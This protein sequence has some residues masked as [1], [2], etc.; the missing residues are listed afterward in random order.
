M[1]GLTRPALYWRTVHTPRKAQTFTIGFRENDFDEAGHAR[2]LPG[3][4]ILITMSS[5]S[6][7]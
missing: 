5:T 1:K 4:L 2:D 3:T 7:G 6:L